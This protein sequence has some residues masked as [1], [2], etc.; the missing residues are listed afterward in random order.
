VAAPFRAALERGVGLPFA[1]LAAAA[2][3]PSVLYVRPGVP[4]PGTTLVA[5]GATAPRLHA[6]VAALAGGVVITEATTFD[7]RPASLASLSA[8]DLWFGVSGGSGF[9]TDDAE[10]HLEPSAALAPS[11][12]P[13]DVSSF[14]YLD[15][16]RGLP[17]LSDLAALADTHLSAGFRRRVAGLASVLWYRTHTAAATRLTVVVS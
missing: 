10:F 5:R 2:R 9:L 8:L 13:A 3:G 14:V 12:L 11:G 7:G 1:K 6:V 4:V 15:V 17:A 16:A